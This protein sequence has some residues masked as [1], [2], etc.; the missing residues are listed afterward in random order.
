MTCLSLSSYH[1]PG[2][3]SSS[4]ESSEEEEVK[5]KP[6]P[7]KKKK[8]TDRKDYKKAGTTDNEFKVR[9]VCHVICCLREQ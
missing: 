7:A 1:L 4:E 9:W 8:D 5:P 2:D 3:S 6:P